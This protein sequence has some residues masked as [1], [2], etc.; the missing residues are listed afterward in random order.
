MFA[1]VNNVPV[2]Y[3]WDPFTGLS[4]SNC[5]DPVIRNI[6]E[7]K[8]YIL[9]VT[10]P[11]GCVAKDTLNI[12]I[13]CGENLWVPNAFT[14]NNNGLN[15]VFYPQAPGYGIVRLM[16]IYDRWGEVV[17]KQ[18]DFPLN[19]SNYGWDGTYKGDKI[20]GPDVY[21]YVIHFICVSG[22]SF[23]FIGKVTVLR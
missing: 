19:D 6:K 13:F 12:R 7:D 23:E 16:T 11:I 2:E 20:A 8:V 5:P 22:E 3:V 4:C 17:F 1:Q 10:S 9:T 18:E 21:T 14:P 15:D